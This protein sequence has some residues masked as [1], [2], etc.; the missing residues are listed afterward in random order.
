[1]KRVILLLC[2]CLC[3]SFCYSQSYTI[4]EA[5]INT[6]SQNLRRL[7]EITRSQREELKSSNESL[8]KLRL[9][10]Q[11]LKEDSG[12]MRIESERLMS[13]QEQQNR[14]IAELKD[15][16][17]KQKTSL[18]RA[19]QSLKKSKTRS[20]LVSTLGII[21]LGVAIKK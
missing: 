11:T 10:L 12:L 1:M 7:Q 15:T 17:A 3:P 18:T 21:A 9:Q 8:A 5:Q 4:S 13:L 2:C 6:L 20:R 19:S 16:V 14:L